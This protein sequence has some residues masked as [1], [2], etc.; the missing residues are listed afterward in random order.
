MTFGSKRFGAR[1]LTPP[2]VPA[3]LPVLLIA[4]SILFLRN[5]TSLLRAE[6]LY[7]DGPIFIQGTFQVGGAILEPYA[8]VG[9]DI[10]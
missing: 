1:T 2:R 10:G 4:A 3:W 5:P 9:K 6:P 7:E 8:T